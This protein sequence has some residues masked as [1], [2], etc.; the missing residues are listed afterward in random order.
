MGSMAFLSRK[1]KWM[2]DGV[3][4]FL[5]LSLRIDGLLGT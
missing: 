4:A 1:G 2:I 5:I 3:L